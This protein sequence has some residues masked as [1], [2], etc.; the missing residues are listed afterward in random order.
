MTEAVNENM[1]PA[2]INIRPVAVN[3]NMR[4]EAVNENMKLATVNFR[5]IAVYENMRT[6]A[7]KIIY[8]IQSESQWILSNCRAFTIIA[9]LE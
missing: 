9:S 6:A 8:H 7:V 3:E 2:A 4:T 5:L 1:R